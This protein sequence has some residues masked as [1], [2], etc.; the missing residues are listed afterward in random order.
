MLENLTP[1]ITFPYVGDSH[2]PLPDI[3]DGAFTY[4]ELCLSLLSY[5]LLSWRILTVTRFTLG[6]GQGRILHL[7]DSYAQGSSV[8]HF[9]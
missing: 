7:L 3:V 2:S 6:L 5:V 8:M 9:T 1:D 4:Y